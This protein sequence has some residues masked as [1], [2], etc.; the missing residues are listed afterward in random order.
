MCF[1]LIFCWI[2][3][4]SKLI[5]LALREGCVWFDVLLNSWLFECLVD[6][7]WEFSEKKGCVWFDV[8][9]DFW[10]VKVENLVRKRVCLVWCFVGFW[11]FKVENL[12]RKRVCLVWCFVGFLVDHWVLKQFLVIRRKGVFW[13][14]V[15][16]SSW[17]IKVE[18]FKY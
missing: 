2:F 18:N 10:L 1:G 8:L 7:D 12:V 16:L 11:L 14:D 15:L 4:W 3:G 5:F 17:L 9:L 6:Q 13:F